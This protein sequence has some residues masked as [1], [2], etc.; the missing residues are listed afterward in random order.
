MKG[1]TKMKKFWKS[2]TFWANLIALAALAL[3]IECGFVV[4]IEL[5]AVALGIVNLAL[6]KYTNEG[7]E[8]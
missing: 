3:Q 1:E 5:Q 8:K 7:L 6:R 4:S 2:K